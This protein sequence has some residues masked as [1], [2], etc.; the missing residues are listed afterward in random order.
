MGWQGKQAPHLRLWD[1][2]R[3]SHVCCLPTSFSLQDVVQVHNVQDGF[4]VLL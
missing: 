2:G 3:V 4:Q 1:K